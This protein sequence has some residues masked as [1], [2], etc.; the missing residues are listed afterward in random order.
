MQSTSYLKIT[1][2]IIVLFVLTL[3]G[4]L[5]ITMIASVFI[6]HHAFTNN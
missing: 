3:L 4:S 1:A 6:S 5:M 2:G